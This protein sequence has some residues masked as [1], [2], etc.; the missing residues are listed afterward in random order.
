[1][2]HCKLRI[3]VAAFV[4]VLGFSA[5]GGGAG[6]KGPID[7]TPP[8]SGSNVAPLIVDAGPT[9]RGVNLPSVSVTVCVPGST[10]CTIIDHVLVDTASIG[11]RLFASQLPAS[12]VLPPAVTGSG[13]PLFECQPFAD[14]YAWGS[15]RR[16]DVQLADGTGSNIAIQLMGDA[17]ATSPVPQACIDAGLGQSVND[18]VSF[19]MN[20]VL[21]VNVFKEDCL[22]CA[23]TP[24]PAA[25]YDCAT[26]PCTP[27]VVALSEEV[28]N[29]VY[30]FATN[31]N[32]VS[33]QL[34]RINAAG[35]TTVNGYLILGIDTQGNNQL[36]SVTV[37][38]VDPSTGN[39]TTNYKGVALTQSIIDSG[40]NGF[41]FNDSALAACKTY[42][43]FYC[44]V[45]ATTLSATNQGANGATKSVA[46]TVVNADIVFAANPTFSAYQNVAGSNPFASSFDWGLPFFFGRR[47]YFAFEQRTTSAGAGPF[48]AY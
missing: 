20:G 47:V 36:G 31:N 34:P 12:V 21:G 33:I 3:L 37:L 6:A 26:N 9:A 17:T 1:M 5:C 27:L 41:F 42:P 32:G 10:Q 46:F 38:T 15:V 22:A 44:P 35:Q 43:G 19:A 2:T 40:S 39:F 28:Q 18:P 29:P 11:L 25:Y 8:P 4:L 24:L 48:V 45:S 30:Q 23:T 7:T 14:G 13:I 16:A